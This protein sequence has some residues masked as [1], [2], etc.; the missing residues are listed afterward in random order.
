MEQTWNSKTLLGNW[1]E[2]R[3]EEKATAGQKRSVFATTSTLTMEAHDPTVYKSVASEQYR[4]PAHPPAASPARMVDTD[5]AKERLGISPKAP[6]VA[7]PDK[8]ESGAAATQSHADHYKTTHELSWVPVALEDSKEQ[9]PAGLTTA[10]VM[11]AKLG[12]TSVRNNSDA[13]A[14]ATGQ[15]AWAA[16]TQVPGTSGPQVQ[17]QA[18][19][20]REDGNLAGLALQGLGAQKIRPPDKRRFY[21]KRND[22]LKHETGIWSG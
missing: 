2:A 17:P 13:R 10:E 5:A 9:A 21:P 11:Q 18:L 14:K 3:H 20:V 22:A 1:Y 12:R 6:V 19:E 4:R 8:T 7:S 15:R 16:A